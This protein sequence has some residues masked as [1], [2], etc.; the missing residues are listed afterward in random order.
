ME[1]TT[2]IIAELTFLETWGKIY[3]QAWVDTKD[4]NFFHFYCTCCDA[5]LALSGKETNF[6]SAEVLP[7]KLVIVGN[8]F[9][10]MAVEGVMT[11][12]IASSRKKYMHSIVDLL[13]GSG[14][15]EPCQPYQFNLFEA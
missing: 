4:S 14:L 1:N 15:C 2:G 5:Y 13:R 12:E 3:K 6:Q 11:A 7:D 9:G 10:Q 8:Y